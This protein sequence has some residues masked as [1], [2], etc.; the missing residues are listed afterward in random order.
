MHGRA[1]RVVLS[2]C[3]MPGVQKCAPLAIVALVY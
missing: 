1:E 2:F 3:E